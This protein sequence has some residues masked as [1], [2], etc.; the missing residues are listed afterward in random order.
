[1]RTYHPLF[2]DA[3]IQVGL[4]SPSAT[5]KEQFNGYLRDAASNLPSIIDVRGVIYGVFRCGKSNL[6]KVTLFYVFLLV[7]QIRF[8]QIDELMSHDLNGNRVRSGS[9]ADGIIDG[10]PVACEGRKA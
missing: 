1:M 2:I 8:S 6:L 10:E 7:F 5:R 3:A 9:L 4:D